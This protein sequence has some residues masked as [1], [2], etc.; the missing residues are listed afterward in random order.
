MRLCFVLCPTE[1]RGKKSPR[2]LRLSILS[3]KTGTTGGRPCRPRRP[4]VL[5]VLVSSSLLCFYHSFVL[6]N[7]SNPIG[8]LVGRWWV[9]LSWCVADAC[10]QTAY[11]KTETKYGLASHRML[12]Y[13]QRLALWIG[14]ITLGCARFLKQKI[15]L[16]LYSLNPV[17][18][19]HIL[20]NHISSSISF[21]RG[22]SFGS[23][24]LELEPWNGLWWGISALWA[25]L[26]YIPGILFESMPFHAVLTYE[27][28]F[29]NAV[30]WGS[31]TL[32]SWFSMSLLSSIVE[33]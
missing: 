26:L 16:A 24:S 23:R 22:H 13:K 19:G 25:F 28:F 7:W 33:I 8:S 29:F 4:L 30:R 31:G 21:N 6:L 32:L 10:L 18:V 17:P 5:L 14:I 3:P 2:R 20:S 1:S 12:C 9:L 15:G 11:Q 27:E